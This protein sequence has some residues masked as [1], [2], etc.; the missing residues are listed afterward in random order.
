[1]HD[2]VYW[3][4]STTQCGPVDRKSPLQ[5]PPLRRTSFS[6][7]SGSPFLDLRSVLSHPSSLGHIQDAKNKVGNHDKIRENFMLKSLRLNKVES[8]L[9]FVN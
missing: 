7:L 8:I 3:Y 2:E 9:R 6:W 5:K 4:S 1:M